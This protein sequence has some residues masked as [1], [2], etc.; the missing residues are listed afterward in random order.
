MTCWIPPELLIY[1][2]ESKLLKITSEK[3]YNARV[4]ERNQ[5]YSFT[6]TLK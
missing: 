6:E 4:Q 5:E 1:K 3:R 2:T